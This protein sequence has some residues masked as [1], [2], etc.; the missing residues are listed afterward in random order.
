M[1]GV[2]PN[3]EYDGREAEEGRHLPGRREREQL[4]CRSVLLVEG[5]VVGRP[6]GRSVGAGLAA[7][8]AAPGAGK[9]EGGRK[10]RVTAEAKGAR[11]DGWDGDVAR[12]T[13]PASPKLASSGPSF[14]VFF[15]ELFD[16]GALVGREVGGDS[17]VDG[18]VVVAAVVALVEGRD[19]LVGELESSAGLRAGGYRDVEGGFVEGAGLEGGAEDGVDGVDV[20]GRVEVLALPREGGVG[21]DAEEDVEVARG[22]ALGA[23]V[24]LA[25]ETELGAVVDAAGDVDGDGLRLAADAVAVAGGAVLVDLLARAAA[26]RARRLGLEVAE[27]RPR[28]LDDEARA[29]AGGAG[30]D[31]GPGLDA[32]ARA[33]VARLEV[34]DL[35]ALLAAEA[36]HVEGQLQVRPE[37]VAAAGHGRRL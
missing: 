5:A 10:G 13:P 35:H 3:Y 25:G 18:D 23:G 31:P 16:E 7:K 21:L 32:G 26:R 4:P 37:V 29:A 34:L 8:T 19:A 6:V 14:V 1:G 30:R 28:H 11:V 27:G 20:E 33:A 36:R 24:A 15:L 2:R 12:P 9:W 17:D 22:P